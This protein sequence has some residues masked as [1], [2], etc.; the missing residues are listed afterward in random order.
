MDGGGSQ[1]QR[2]FSKAYRKIF[3]KAFILYDCITASVLSFFFVFFILFLENLRRHL[4]ILIYMN[5]IPINN[6]GAACEHKLAAQ[7][8]G[9]TL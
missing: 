7:L 4:P 6:P 3:S 1:Q 2:L 5:H 9:V 8:K